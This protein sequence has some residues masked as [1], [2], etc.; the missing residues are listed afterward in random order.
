MSADNRISVNLSSLRVTYYLGESPVKTWKC[1]TLEEAVKKAQ[2]L[3]EEYETEY[4]VSFINSLPVVTKKVSP[5]TKKTLRSICKAS[6]YCYWYLCPN[7]LE[8]AIG[9]GD[10][11]C[12]NCGLNLKD[13]KFIQG[14]K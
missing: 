5:K 3:D 4:G 12:P 11:F 14:K 10:S 7:C 8:G 9:D 1:K 2:E 6:R 13:Y